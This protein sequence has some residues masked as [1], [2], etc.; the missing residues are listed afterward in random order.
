MKKINREELSFLNG[1]GKKAFRG[2]MVA[3]LIAAAA[4]MMTSCKKV[5]VSS[6][7][8]GNQVQVDLIFVKDDIKM[9][10]FEDNGRYHYFTSRGETITSQTSGSGKNQ[11]HYEENIQ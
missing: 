6:S 3:I 8:E 4:V 11:T 1:A 10:R 2:I 7:T 5:A 9:Y